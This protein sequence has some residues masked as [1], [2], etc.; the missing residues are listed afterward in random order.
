[1]I[2]DVPEV[3]FTHYVQAG[4][5]FEKK[6]E[7]EISNIEAASKLKEMQDKLFLIK[8]LLN[9]GDRYLQN[10]KVR[11]NDLIGLVK[12]N[13]YAELYNLI[14][15]DLDDEMKNV[16]YSLMKYILQ[17]KV[18]GDVVLT[19]EIIEQSSLEQAVATLQ[20]RMVV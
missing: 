4:S 3:R 7:I 20:G 19:F 14:K 13:D 1:M 18:F 5:E 12:Y 17:F 16:K 11:L 15:V 8:Q 9:D 10:E 2:S 6:L